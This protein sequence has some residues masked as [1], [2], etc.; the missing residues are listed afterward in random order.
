VSTLRARRGALPSS[1]CSRTRWSV[2]QSRT[3]AQEVSCLQDES[4][5]RYISLSL[6]RPLALFVRQVEPH[7]VARQSQRGVERQPP[8]P[9]QLLGI[10]S[11]ARVR[12]RSAFFAGAFRFVGSS[13]SLPVPRAVALLVGPAGRRVAR[14]VDDPAAPS[15]PI[16]R[17]SAVRRGITSDADNSQGS[18]FRLLAPFRIICLDNN[19]LSLA[20]TATKV[21]S[22][23]AGSL[24]RV[25]C[26]F[27]GT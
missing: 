10:T 5:Y 21:L 1:A 13:S 27:A 25:P 3:Q 9:F 14:S 12:P 15:W 19:V 7:V 20:E 24:A 2:T 11:L 18:L 6:G 17:P 16:V 8:L 23:L 4:V 26:L 22:P